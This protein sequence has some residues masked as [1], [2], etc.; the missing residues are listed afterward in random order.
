[1]TKRNTK[2]KYLKV[3]KYLTLSFQDE[4]NC[5]FHGADKTRRGGMPIVLPMNDLMKTGPQPYTI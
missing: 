2:K 1:M 4:R 3:F 5:N